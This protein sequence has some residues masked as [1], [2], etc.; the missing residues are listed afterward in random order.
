MP[1]KTARVACCVASLVLLTLLVGPDLASAQESKSGAA[2]KELAET[3]DRLK[4]DSI[5]APDPMEKDTFVAALYFPGAQLLVVSARYS[6]P[7]LLVTKLEKKEYRDTYIDLNAASVVATK[8]FVMDQ[9]ADGLIAKPGDSQ[10]A[11]TWELANKTTAFDGD[12]KKAKISEDEYQK[13]FSEADERYARIL[14]LLTQQA[15][16]SGS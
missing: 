13:S 7:S 8:I 4:L 11:D 3:L 9:G 15:R 6:A 16:K 12:W 2:A 10:A 5:A 1:T 14:S